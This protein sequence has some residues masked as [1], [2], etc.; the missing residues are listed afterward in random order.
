[1]KEP[2]YHCPDCNSD[3]VATEYHQKI[4]VNTD[5]HYNHSMKPYDSDSPAT[6][7]DCRWR[8]LRQDL[9]KNT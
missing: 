5:E 4:M 8:G 6:C 2:T 1:M 3:R 7:L 9:K